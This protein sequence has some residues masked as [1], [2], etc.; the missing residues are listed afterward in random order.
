MSEAVDVPPDSSWIDDIPE[1]DWTD[2]IDTIGRVVRDGGRVLLLAHA[3]PDGDALGSLLALH[4]AMRSQGVAS[5]ASWGSEPFQVP[6]QYTFL[7]GLASLTPPEDVPDHVD[8][9]ITLDAATAERLGVLRDRFDAADATLVIDHHASNTR[10][11]DK[12]LISARAA[13]TAVMVEELIHRL[14]GHVDRDIASCLYVGLVTDTGRFQYANTDRSAMELGSRLIGSGIKHDA[15][16]RQMFET[17]SFGYLKVIA[18]VLERAAFLPE[19]SLVYSW[20]TQA[21]LERYGVALEETEGLIDIL[22]TVDSAEVVMMIKEA[23]GGGWRVSLRSKSRI[24]VGRLASELQG[25]GH[26]FSAGFSSDKPLEEVVRSVVLP[27]AGDGR[28]RVPDT[29]RT[30]P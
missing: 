26:A 10:F 14:G 24:D 7:P 3:E 29:G 17:H 1:D 9:V 28:V 11:G 13:A 4:L 12:N 2:A 19:A 20:V 23:P 16:N 22:R 18:R 8:L 30:E 15:M 6:P 21:D 25:G 27:L 5:I